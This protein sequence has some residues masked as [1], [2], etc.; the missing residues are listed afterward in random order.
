[1]HLMI[2]SILNNFT[3]I[4][5]VEELDTQNVLRMISVSLTV[6]VA[7]SS[8]THRKVITVEER[9]LFIFLPFI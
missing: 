1:M 7:L 6:A 4:G 3:A 8:C 9:Y 5:F 2:H